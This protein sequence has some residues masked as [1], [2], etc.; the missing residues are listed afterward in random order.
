M[1]QPEEYE[2][3]P[4]LTDAMMA[5][6]DHYVGDRLVRRG[7]PSRTGARIGAKAGTTTAV[8]I[9]LSPA[10]LAHFRG[11]GPGWQARID[12][13]LRKV[14]EAERSQRADGPKRA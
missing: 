8:S 11:S 1:V 7:R 3:L 13:I 12:E 9:R 4:E 10:V 5:R 2:D 14:V 6:A